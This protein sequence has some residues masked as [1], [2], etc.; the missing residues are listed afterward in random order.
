MQHVNNV[1][2]DTFR[3]DWIMTSGFNTLSYSISG[4]HMHVV[5]EGS[6]LRN[7]A[8]KI[9][10]LNEGKAITSQHIKVEKD[11]AI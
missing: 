3:K 4:C 1:D 5:Q 2:W 11:R 9:G 7:H 6:Y 8:L 10:I